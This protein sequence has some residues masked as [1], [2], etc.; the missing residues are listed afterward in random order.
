MLA[1]IGGTGIYQLDGLEMTDTVEVATPFGAP[2]AGI[3]RGK[4]GNHDI[5]FLARH[6]QRHQ[7][8]P[9]EVNYRANIF[10]LKSL[11][12]TQILGISAVGSLDESIAPG[13]LAMPDQYVD[14]TRGRRAQTFFGDGVAVHVSTANPVSGALVSWVAGHASALGIKLH[15]GVT[16]ACVEGPRL[17]TR[18]E[19]HLLR[20][21]G[22]HLVGMTNVPEAF[23]AREA[24]MCYATIGIATDYDCW[25][26]DP[27]RHVQAT[28]IFGLYKS[29]L[30]KVLQLLQRV[31]AEDRPA[32]ETATR[33][34]L[35]Y[36]MLTP[37]SALTDQQRDWFAVL[38]R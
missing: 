38:L 32:E 8:L 18:A 14:W 29:S 22:C 6:G 33:T 37:Q 1:I 25:M 12:A 5:L 3:V 9:H 30:D 17:G 34:A 24:Q 31:L 10:A 21:F 2:S 23:L 4:M 20:Q 13:D 35:Q 26:D 7:Y 27:D 36:A 28:E 15:S 11:G 16:Y 19:S